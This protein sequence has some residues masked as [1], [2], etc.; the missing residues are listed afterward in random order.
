M[1]GG[2]GNICVWIDIDNPPQVQ[3]LVPFEEAFRSSG[4][5]VVLTAR[6]YG[7]ALELLA[8][9]EVSFDAVGK[10][11]GRSKIVKAV[12]L[13]RRARALASLVGRERAPD[14][15]LSASRASALAARWMGIPSFVIAD[16]EYANSSFYRLTGSTILYPDVI[17]PA[18][19]LASGIS[20]DQLIAFRGL[21]E[22]IS[23]AGI[24]VDEVVP[25]RFPEIQNDTLVRVLFRPPT[26]TSH[27]YEPKSRD[28]ALRTLEHLAPQSEAV[29]VF[30]PRHPWQQD[31]LARLEWRNEPVVLDRAVSFVSLL[32]AVDLVVCS[33]GTMLREAAYLGVPAYSILK[34]RIGGV[35][36]YLASIGR[37][38]LINS[39]DELSALEL[40]KAPSL[41]PL[42]SNPGLLD[43]LVEIV[44]ERTLPTDGARAVS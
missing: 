26:E 17:D 41:S 35:D 29:V 43:E 36:R 42:R 20:R 34:S 25:Y 31:D 2:G 4:A 19:L 12:G 37:A 30:L 40:R 39:P 10:E 44:L 5:H 14:V 28:L 23:L 1:A 27:Y 13:L 21:K 8:Q 22:D 15:L 38:R 16:Y 18:P 32:K 24:D 7:N 11:L 9:R 3:Y 33:G 6:D